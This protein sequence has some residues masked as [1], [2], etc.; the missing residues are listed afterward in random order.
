MKR[1]LILVL[2]VLT[3]TVGFAQARPSFD[4]IASGTGKFSNGTAAAP[5]I[6]FGSDPDTGIYRYGANQ[7]GFSTGGYVRAYIDANNLIYSSGFSIVSDSVDG[8]DNQFLKL[9]GGGIGGS[10]RG[11]Y[12][13][14]NGNE[15]AALGGLTLSAGNVAGGSV[16]FNT[17]AVERG[18]FTHGGNLIIGTTTD[19]GENRLQVA[20]GIAQPL[21]FSNITGYSLSA[22]SGSL[23][24]D[25][26]LTTTIS[27]NGFTSG[28]IHFTSG[29]ETSPA[30]VS[31]VGTTLTLATGSSAN[32]S[33]TKNSASKFNIYVEDNV[34]KIQN[35]RGASK[36]VAIYFV[37][38]K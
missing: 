3:V 9:C 29:S 33:V 25:G 34:I 21:G 36:S 32:V 24:N 11:A 27:A 19:D 12:I 14:L 17:Q 10:S 16:K 35:K 13:D 1:L 5:S 30:Q 18:R 7:I 15:T 2:M 28:T 22:G 23:A 8:S 31:L 26:V 6:T 38:I 37:G 20:G 4:Q